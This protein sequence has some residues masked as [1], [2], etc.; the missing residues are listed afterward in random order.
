MLY[1]NKNAF[2]TLYLNIMHYNL[3]L[4]CTSYFLI[5]FWCLAISVSFK[6]HVSAYR[7]FHGFA[8]F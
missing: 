5:R 3:S 1:N 2:G 7:V 4:N 8:Y 6:V